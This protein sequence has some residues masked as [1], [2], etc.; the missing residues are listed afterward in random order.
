MLDYKMLC[1]TELLVTQFAEQCCV[2][3]FLKEIF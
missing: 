3:L 1:S 2:G